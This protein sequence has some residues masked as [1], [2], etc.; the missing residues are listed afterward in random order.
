VVR[1]SLRRRQIIVQAHTCPRHK[2]KSDK[3]W[4]VASNIAKIPDLLTKR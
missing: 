4:R 2:L 1:V 3:A